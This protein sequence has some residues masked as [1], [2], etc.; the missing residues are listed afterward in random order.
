[1]V[2]GSGSGT[3][4]SHAA[5]AASATC[6]VLVAEVG[7]EGLGCPVQLSAAPRL[8]SLP[9]KLMPAEGTTRHVTLRNPTRAQVVVRATGELTCALG[10]LPHGLGGMLGR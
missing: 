9:G 4:R 8:V 5:I 6:D 1:M 2:R 3:G 10:F 7:L